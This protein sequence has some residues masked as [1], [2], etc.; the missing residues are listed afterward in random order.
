MRR[1]AG[2]TRPA[3]PARAAASGGRGR[4]ALTARAPRPRLSPLRAGAEGA[5]GKRLVR[6]PG[7]ATEGQGPTPVVTTPVPQSNLATF[8]NHR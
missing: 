3:A 6:C 2:C 1:G 5:P 4:G 7:A 8:L